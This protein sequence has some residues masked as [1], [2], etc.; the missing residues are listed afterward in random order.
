MLIV[1]DSD[2]VHNM[3]HDNFGIMH[4][5]ST[6]IMWLAS[7]LHKITLAYKEKLPKKSK[8]S[9]YPMFLW[10]S[11]PLHK[12]FSDNNL[13]QKFNTCLD[14]VVDTF[15]NMKMIRMKKEWEFDDPSIFRLG[16]FSSEGLDRYW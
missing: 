12:N 10:V 1:L 9:D 15:S 7:E 6:S 8:K 11:A 5:L 4:M 16:K 14:K 3:N 13:H 2:L